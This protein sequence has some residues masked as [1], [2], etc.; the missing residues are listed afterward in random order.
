[1]YCSVELVQLIVHK[2]T[3]ILPAAKALYIA[4]T[5]STTFILVPPSLR[6]GS[7][8]PFVIKPFSCSVTRHHHW[9]GVAPLV[10]VARAGGIA[11]SLAVSSLI[12]VLDCLTNVGTNC[13]KR[14]KGAVRHNEAIGLVKIAVTRS[15][16]RPR[17]SVR[18][19]HTISRKDST[20]Q[21][22]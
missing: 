10:V 1:M 12:L 15:G 18:V 16:R 21:Q 13:D 3:C 19:Y 5:P 8:L 2:R 20:D 17:S 4:V 6:T 22:Q 7:L 9:E 14:G 11:L